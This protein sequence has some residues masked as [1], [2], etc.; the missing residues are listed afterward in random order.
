MEFEFR[1]TGAGW[2]EG[3]LRSGDARVLL[4]AS[5]LS[6]ALG[7]LIAAVLRVFDDRSARCFWSEEPGEF[8]WLFDR[9][10][11]RVRTRIL[12]FDEDV[13]EPDE[14]GVLRFDATVPLRELA[15]AVHAGVDAVLRRYGREGYEEQWA[16]APFPGDALDALQARLAGLD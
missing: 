11:D 10:G 2:A 1:L 4:T 6:D 12:W 13:D 14:T 3:Q 9:E 16:R 7:D 8:W 15:S 5:Y